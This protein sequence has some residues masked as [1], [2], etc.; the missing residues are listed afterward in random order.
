LQDRREGTK[1]LCLGVPEKFLPRAFARLSRRPRRRR[2]AHLGG[3][4]RNVHE[5]KD[6][7]PDKQKYIK[8]K[9]EHENWCI[10]NRYE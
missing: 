6:E 3:G 2:G 9:D 5:P 7:S 4:A 1:E 10:G 8:P